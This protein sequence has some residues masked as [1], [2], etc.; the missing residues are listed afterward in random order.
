MMILACGILLSISIFLLLETNII[1]RVFGIV[2]FSSVINLIILICGRLNGFKPTFVSPLSM[3]HLANP[4][5][6][7]LILTAI[8]IGFGLLAF[9]CALLKQLLSISKQYQS[10]NN[11]HGQKFDKL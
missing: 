1:R 4:L 5:P 11:E 9:L 7:A 10:D 2:L 3:N 8:V 6:Q